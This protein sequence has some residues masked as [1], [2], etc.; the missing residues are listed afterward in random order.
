MGLL[1]VSSDLEVRIV[2]TLRPESNWQKNQL[3]LWCSHFLPSA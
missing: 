2:T 3:R 1:R